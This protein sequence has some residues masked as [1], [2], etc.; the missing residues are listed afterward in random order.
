MHADPGFV[1][2]AM[3]VVTHA[4]F[5]AVDADGD[6]AID[7]DEYARTFTAIN[8]SKDELARAGFN[9]IDAD[10]DGA[11]SRA[12]LIDAMHAVFCSTA[13]P[14]SVGARVLR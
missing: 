14:D 3:L 7:I 8:P 1:D 4:I 13:V 10:G 6:G 5:T 2:G 12:E 9:I 11:I